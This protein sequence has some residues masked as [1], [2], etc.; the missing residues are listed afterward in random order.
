MKDADGDMKAGVAIGAGCSL[1][2]MGVFCML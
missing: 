1:K 2:N